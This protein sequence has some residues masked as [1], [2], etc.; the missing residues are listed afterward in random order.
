MVEFMAGED[1]TF[2]KSRGWTSTDVDLLQAF[3]QYAVG[4]FT[5]MAGKFTTLAGA[6]VP[7]APA[8]ANISR[9]LL[10]TNAIPVSHTGLRSSFAVS[11]T[12][13]FTLGVNNGWDIIRESNSGNCLTTTPTTCA[14]GKTVE[15]G[16]SATPVKPLSLTASYYSGDEYSATSNQI[17]NRS[18]IDAVL[19]FA[20]TDAL[21]LVLNYDTGEQEKAT[22]TAGTAKWNGTAA[23]V[24]YAFTD[25]LRGSFRLES[26]DDKSCIRTTCA[27]GASSQKLKESTVTVGYMVAKGFELRGEYRKD[28]SNG[29]VFT[30]DGAATDKQT[31][32]GV[33]AV[34]KF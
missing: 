14:D 7:Q 3:A 24:N 27:A 30:K 17:G 10:Y 4:P 34:Y 31:F 23:Y 21:T 9:S 22:A 26:F 25:K 16:V 8:N 33:E 5:V 18:L 6:E 28:D 12:L 20:A 29:Q 32:Y 2:N 15:L 19:S 13:K 1:V 11:D